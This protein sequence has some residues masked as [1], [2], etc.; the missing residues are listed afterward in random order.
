[1]A[2]NMQTENKAV[3]LDPFRYNEFEGFNSHNHIVVTEVGDGTSVVEVKLVQESLNPLGMAHGG[4]IFTLCDVATGVAAR[5][6]GRITV[7]LDSSIQFLRPG[8]DT[9]KLVAH[10]RVVKEGRTTGLVTAEV[11]NDAGELLAT[12]SV[13]VY[14]VDENTYTDPT[15][16]K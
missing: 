7:T 15:V 9:S 5:T 1:M 16:Q 11:F 13:M 6:G 2:Q 4:L 12:A 3:Y 8:K 10:G 14:Y